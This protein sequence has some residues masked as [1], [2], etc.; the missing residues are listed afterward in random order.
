MCDTAHQTVQRDSFV[1]VAGLL[2]TCVACHMHGM[3]SS[4]VWRDAFICVAC[5]SFMC[6]MKHA[7]VGC[8]TCPFR[9]CDVLFKWDMSLS[10]L[11]HVIHLENVPFVIVAWMCDVSLFTFV[12][13]THFIRVDDISHSHVWHVSFVCVSCL[14]RVCDILV[15]VWDISR[16]NVWHVP[17]LCDL[18]HSCMKT[19][20]CIRATARLHACVSWIR[21]HSIYMQ[22]KIWKYKYEHTRI[23]EYECV[24]WRIHEDCVMPL[25]PRMRGTTY[26]HVCHDSFTCVKRNS[27]K[28]FSAKKFPCPNAD[29]LTSTCFTSTCFTSTCL[30]YVRTARLI[31][32]MHLCDMPYSRAGNDLFMCACSYAYVYICRCDLTR[33]W[34]MCAD[35]SNSYVWHGLFTYM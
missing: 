13:V 7:L 6:E 26:P 32:G 20:Q 30:S 10:Y 24:S 1:C 34:E 9:I 35:C 22:I 5:I 28:E 16:W 15:W 4:W 12:C 18:F 31:F 3:T 21:H 8:V 11:W 29:Q 27:C 23:N 2:H 14:I 19:V 33:W 17:L 25:R